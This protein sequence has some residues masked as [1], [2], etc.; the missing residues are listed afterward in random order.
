MTEGYFEIEP[1][2]RQCS[3][4]VTFVADIPTEVLEVQHQNCRR[5]LC[6]RRVLV[7]VNRRETVI[8]WMEGSDDPCERR[9]EFFGRY[10]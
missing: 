6:V 3:W 10:E 4:E 9:E 8:D 7:D 1:D 2:F 5:C